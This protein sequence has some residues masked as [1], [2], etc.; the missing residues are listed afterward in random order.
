MAIVL[1]S[2]LTVRGSY[3]MVERGFDS[4]R[5]DSLRGDS[6]R[7]AASF[8]LL[9]VKLRFPLLS[10]SDIASVN[11]ESAKLINSFEFLRFFA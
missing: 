9:N 4:L 6:L 1:R 8:P 3:F 2:T 5:G 10:L 7:G 11:Y